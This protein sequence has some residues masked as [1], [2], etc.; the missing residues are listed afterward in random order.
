MKSEEVIKLEEKLNK[1]TEERKFI[2]R[3]LDEQSVI[4]E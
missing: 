4:I 3:I 1:L 2:D